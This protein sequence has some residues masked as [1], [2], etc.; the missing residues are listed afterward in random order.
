MEDADDA[1]AET[2]AVAWRKFASLPGGDRAR[3]WLFGAARNELHKAMNRRRAQD[4]LVSELQ[5]ELG[6]V[7]AEHL[8]RG[9]RDDAL[10]AALRTLSRLD[11]EIVMLTAWEELTPR[12]I[13]AVLGM[14]ANVVRVRLHR[15]R[16][17]LRSLLHS[18]Q[19][20][21]SGRDC[22]GLA[23]GISRAEQGE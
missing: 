12:E 18:G 7:L 2:Y 10:R 5:T 23:L 22:D 3:L 8:D 14:S 19:H 1:L 15:A 6:P 16:A 9:Q 11:Y 20:S 13:A 21:R 17:Q 4:S